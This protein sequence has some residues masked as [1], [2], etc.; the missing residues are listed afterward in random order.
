MGWYYGTSQETLVLAGDVI[1]TQKRDFPRVMDW[2]ERATF[3]G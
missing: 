3:A 1:E 2:V